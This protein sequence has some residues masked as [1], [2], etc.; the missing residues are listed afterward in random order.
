MLRWTTLVAALALLSGCPGFGDKTLAE[1]E[2]I[3][4]TPVTYNADIR[5]ILEARC[6]TCHSDPPRF[7]APNALT[8]YATASAFAQRIFVRVVQEGTMPPGGGVPESE[9]ALIEVWVQS[10]APEG[11]ADAPDLGPDLDAGPDPEPDMQPGRDQGPVV[12]M[13]PNADAAPDMMAPPPTWNDDVAPVMDQNCAFPGCHGGANPQSNLD[14]S[15]YAGYL[16]G[17]FGGDL[18]GG[19]DPAQSGLVDRLRARDGLPLMPQ[20]G[21]MLPEE[22]IQMIEAW[23]AA[24]SPEG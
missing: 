9:Q 6:V 23:I 10:G 17:G 1:L 4:D 24:G 21:P 8:T 14:L 22:T 16:A 13:D 3:G 15:T 5:P 7:G 19:G 12:D 18:T 2:G 11:E 20:G